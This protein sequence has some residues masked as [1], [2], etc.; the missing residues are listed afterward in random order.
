MIIADLVKLLQ[1]NQLPQGVLIVSS[2]P[3]VSIEDFLNQTFVGT[4]WRQ[5]P[6]VHWFQGPLLTVDEARKIRSLATR[7]QANPTGP[8]RFFIISTETLRDEAQNALLKI[9]EEPVPDTYFLLVIKSEQLILP[10]LRS[11]L[12]V[13]IASADNVLSVD[14]LRFLSLGPAARIR[15]V[16]RRL[17]EAGENGSGETLSRWLN[18]L[19]LFL[20]EKL[21]NSAGN[22]EW[23]AALREVAR[24]RRYFG[25]QGS[26]D[27]LL[28]EHLA[29]VLPKV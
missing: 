13:F 7:R 4:G 1:L 19:E 12:Q 26:A 29:L 8:G 6:D 17:S 3:S 24:V 16:I 11:R 23:T 22:S 2:T 9:I 27:R 21:K 20:V 15:E 5:S 28:L 18:N 10:T 14:T 25:K